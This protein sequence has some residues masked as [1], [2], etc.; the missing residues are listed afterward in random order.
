MNVS[1]RDVEMVLAGRGDDDALSEAEQAVVRATW[2]ES[3][4]VD[5]SDLNFEAAGDTWVVG[6]QHGQAVVKQAP[7]TAS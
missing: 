3:I 1:I 5:I 7:P 4:A 6:D 2:D